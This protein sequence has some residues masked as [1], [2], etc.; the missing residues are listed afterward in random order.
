MWS[1]PAVLISE[2]LP[3][4]PTTI[5]GLFFL[6]TSSCLDRFAPPNRF[7]IFQSKQFVNLSHNL[8]THLPRWS[9]NNSFNLWFLDSFFISLKRFHRN[10][11]MMNKQQQA[12]NSLSICILSKV[13]SHL[14]FFMNLY[15]YYFWFFW[16]CWFACGGWYCL[17]DVDLVVVVAIGD[18]GDGNNGWWQY[19]SVMVVFIGD[20][21]DDNVHR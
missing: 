17:G 1:F 2:I 14:K 18:V 8:H 21:G 3:G 11:M 10:K 7:L 4:A 15:H 6:R 20:V 12:V 13:F 9:N 19:L 16:R 5:D